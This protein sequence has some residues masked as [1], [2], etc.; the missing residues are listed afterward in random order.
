MKRC[1][2]LDDNNNEQKVE[3][4]IPV[5]KALA[6]CAQH[7]GDAWDKLTIADFGLTFLK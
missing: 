6:M 1:S 5:E 2:E 3:E 7:M 4:G